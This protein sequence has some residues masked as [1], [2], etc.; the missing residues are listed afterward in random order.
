M[1][2]EIGQLEREF[3]RGEDRCGPKSHT[4]SGNEERTGETTDCGA[5][6]HRREK[7]APRPQPYERNS[8]GTPIGGR[9]CQN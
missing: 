4:N 3:D 1:P 6:T 7:P 2:Q 9:E 8:K 5:A